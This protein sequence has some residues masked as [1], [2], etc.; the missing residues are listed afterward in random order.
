[1]SVDGFFDVVVD[2]T[3][4][5]DWVVAAEVDATTVLVAL[6][7]TDSVVVDGVTFSVEE[8]NKVV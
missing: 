1:M 7:C 6:V 8:G 4:D 2:S 3:V 5:V